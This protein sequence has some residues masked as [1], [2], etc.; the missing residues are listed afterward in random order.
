MKSKKYEVFVRPAPDDAKV[1]V[2]AIK[3]P[4][5]RRNPTKPKTMAFVSHRRFT[6]Q[7]N[8]KGMADYLFGKLNWKPTKA[9]GH[10]AYMTV[11]TTP[12]A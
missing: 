9:G 12:R 3:P 1:F 8:G 4:V 7:E 10:V 11:S 5:F 2:I 6:S